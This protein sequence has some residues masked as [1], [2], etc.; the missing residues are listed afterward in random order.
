LP[1]PNCNWER[2]SIP[3]RF[4]CNKAQKFPSFCDEM[5][6]PFLNLPFVDPMFRVITKNYR[7]RLLFVHIWKLL[8]RNTTAEELCGVEKLLL[9]NCRRK[10]TIW[11]WWFMSNNYQ[12][13]DKILISNNYRWGQKSMCRNSHQRNREITFEVTMLKLRL[14]KYVKE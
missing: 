5:H 4:S 12:H 2:T 7:W 13:A 3:L 9:N 14:G 11:D 10:I 1:N 8:V 6:I